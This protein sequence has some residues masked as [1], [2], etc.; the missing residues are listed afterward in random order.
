MPR[1]GLGLF[2]ASST[3][4][5]R[6]N[7]MVPKFYS[8]YMGQQ[9]QANMEADAYYGVSI[10]DVAG[11][12]TSHTTGIIP[13]FGCSMTTDDGL[14][15]TA[16][17]VTG[18]NDAHWKQIITNI[19]GGG[20]YKEV[21]I[22][23]GYEAALHT[24]DSG[25]DGTAGWA[26]AW[27]PAFHHVSTVLRA[28]A[29]LVPGFTI[30]IIFDTVYMNYINIAQQSL[31]LFKPDPAFY[32]IMSVDFYSGNLYP[33]TLRPWPG[34]AAVAP[35]TL[36]W[37][38]G[39]AVP[40]A[41]V[42]TWATDFS[43][44]AAPNGQGYTYDNLAHFFAFAD[45]GDTLPNGGG[46]QSFYT[47]VQAAA[48]DQRPLFHSECGMISWGG[49]PGQG[50]SAGNG[51]KDIS[52]TPVVARNGGYI[53]GN[54]LNFF[55]YLKRIWA[56]IESQFGVPC[57]GAVLW[58]TS[59]ATLMSGP[60]ALSGLMHPGMRPTLQ[61]F[62][63]PLGQY[64]AV[65]PVLVVNDV[66][67]ALTPGVP[68]TIQIDANYNLTLTNLTVDFG[69]GA[70]AAALPAGAALIGTQSVQIP[71]TP[72]LAGPFNIT[73]R[74][75]ALGYSSPP[76]DYLVTVAPP[77]V[78][79]SNA[80]YTALAALG[81]LMCVAEFRPGTVGA[82]DNTFVLSTLVSALQTQLPK[83]VFWQQY[84]DANPTGVGWGMASVQGVAPALSLP[85]V[86]NRGEFAVNPP[87][88]VRTELLT[89]TLSD[90]SVITQTQPAGTTIT[91]QTLV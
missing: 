62:N 7:G 57:L 52:T 15:T 30:R 56:Q 51:Y 87:T 24:T 88:G 33:E 46:G 44:H 13:V 47:L 65:D 68:T 34:Y 18:A 16:T 2:N 38:Q 3:L 77:S 48:A 53:A 54:D 69:A 80:D 66:P 81:K 82:G 71:Y 42:D 22:R 29:A 75:T 40:S 12:F 73:A 45:A 59:N 67:T 31:A 74:D 9:T 27:K 78:S 61:V 89:I 79:S 91:S 49:E 32:D 14:M 41:N 23:L 28:A 50:K 43:A 37:A 36:N 26:A 63:Y 85:W 20:G 90:G 39:P 17:I 55:P 19:S 8:A 11:R 60:D 64:G 25:Y 4:H 5:K 76:S 21:W 72:Q 35:F 86:L 58:D 84:W 1:I 6:Q 70:G 83:A 10:N